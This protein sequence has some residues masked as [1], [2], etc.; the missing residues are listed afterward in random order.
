M[1]NVMEAAALTIRCDSC[2][3]AGVAFWHIS[4][5]RCAA[6]FSRYR[7]MPDIDQAAPVKL[8]L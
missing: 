6:E 2:C 1:I 4:S 3:I 5:S 8:D 7:D